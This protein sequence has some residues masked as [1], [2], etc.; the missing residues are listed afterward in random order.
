[1]SQLAFAGRQPTRNLAQALRVT[2]LTEQHGDHLRPT[3]EAARMMLGLVFLDLGLKRQAR[4]KLQNLTEN[5]AYSIH[6]GV[7]V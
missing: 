6:G 7:S 1:M 3:A 4:D 5:A 2:R